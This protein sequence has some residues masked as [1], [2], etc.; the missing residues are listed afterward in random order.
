M[1]FIELTQENLESEHICCALGAK[2]YE[3]AV[4]EKKSWLSERMEEG[5]TFY[6]L[7]ERAKVFIEYLPAEAAWVPV[8]APNYMVINCLWVSGKYKGSGHGRQLLEHCE[9]EARSKGMDGIV[10]LLGSKKMPFLSDKTFFLHH[11]F[12]VTDQAPPYFELVTHKWNAAAPNPRFNDSARQL[13][14][15][16]SGI[17]VYFTAQCPFAVGILGEW[18]AIARK[19]NIPFHAHQIRTREE[20]QAAPAPW[21][22]FAFF[23]NGRYVSHEIMSGNKLEKVLAKLLAE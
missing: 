22:T 9:Q 12:T 23:Y 21:T 16:E 14:V 15:G 19:H 4:K 18:E 13:Q 3:Q 17:T 20:A 11:G 5:L 6:R 8:H 1:S 10:H 2:Q 7:D